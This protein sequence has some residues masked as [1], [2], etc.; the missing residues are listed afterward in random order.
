MKYLKYDLEQDRFINRFLTTDTFCKPQKFKKAVLRG[1]VNE[2]L[3]YGFSIHENPCRKEFLA[4]RLQQTP[5]YKDLSNKLPGERVEVFEQSHPLFVYFP[6]GNVNV[7]CSRF[8]YVPTF[9]RT[10]SAAML[11]CSKAH[12]ASLE[13]CTCGGM[14]LWLNDALVCDFTP[15]T[16]N[17][18]KK[19][20]V[21]VSLQEG[22]NKIVVC[23]DDLAE[24]DTDY[25]FRIAYSGEDRPQIW[26]PVAD[27]VNTDHIHAGEALMNSLYF[28]RDVYMDEDVTLSLDNNS[29]VPIDMNFR[30]TLSLVS[31]RIHKQETLIRE[32]SR[33]LTPGSNR[34]LLFRAGE[35]APSFYFLQVGITLD[36]IEISRKIGTQVFSRALMERYSPDIEQRR[37]TLQEYVYECCIPNVYHCAVEYLLGKESPETEQTLLEE[38]DGIEM[39]KDCSDFH[40]VMVLYLYSR[41]SSRMSDRLKARIRDVAVHFRYWID[42]PGDDVM[43]FFS[44]NHALLF[45]ICQY[46]AGTLFPQD[47]FTASGR[48]GAQQK[49]R[50]QVLLQEWFDDFF[51][52]FITEWNS[53]AYIPVDTLGLGT[54]YAFTAPDSTFH[55]YARR[56]LDAIFRNLSINAFNG[57]IM[58]SFGRSYEEQ[59]KG[60]YISGTSSLLYFAFN[61]GCVNS[62]TNAYISLLMRDYVP[63]KDCTCNLDISPGQAMVF[64]NTQGYENHVNLYLFKNHSVLLSTA[65]GFKPYQPG[66]Q[67]HIMQAVADPVAQLF[68]THPGESQPYGNGRPNYWAGNGTL[69]CA[70]Q[71]LNTGVM[72]YDIAPDH[73]IDYT[74]A[75]FPI[76]HFDEVCCTKTCLAGKKGSAYLGAIALNGLQPVET[77]PMRGREFRSPGKQ[78]VW[79][80]QVASTEKYG[81][82][83]E[84]TSE[85]QRICVSQK[86]A[87]SA[88]V[89]LADGTVL[90]V[91][92]DGTLFVNSKPV[93]EYPMTP[94]GKTEIYK[95]AF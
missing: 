8:Y 71:Y 28:D 88:T 53:N 49:E 36:Q 80:L 38:L 72:I 23:L 24:R 13:L 22:L 94:E 47:L 66:Y 30:Y 46:E 73:L 70:I 9:L 12:T 84:F 37:H 74:H 52:E 18:R 89:Q 82:L 58:T 65:V 79:V 2:W 11:Y 78:N 10:Y 33:T 15:F 4:Q 50:A 85:L 61:K 34:V 26:L 75:Y 51:R 39:R 67:E 86:D 57:A 14:T 35:V 41:F 56:A 6:F 90:D 5:T 48:T 64:R 16:R 68:V 27:T 29:S 83:A 91:Q 20:T 21:S 3:K 95:G 77:G 32:F 92:A 7:E 76:M 55:Q 45:H 87:R 25:Y 93:Y 40:F 81:S 42:E 62:G 63:P 60:N 17:M 54:L 59:L 19:T 43:W 44:E 1:R 69:P 31:G